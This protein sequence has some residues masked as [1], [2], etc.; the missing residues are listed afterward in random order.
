MTFHDLFDAV[1]VFA[2]TRFAYGIPALMA[3]ILLGVAL[4]VG[5][6]QISPRTS[7]EEE[8]PYGLRLVIIVALGFHTFAEGLLARGSLLG[9][10]YH[11]S[12]VPPLAM[13]AFEIHKALEGFSLAG[14][15]RVAGAGRR[16][17]FFISFAVAT[18][19][20]VGFQF[21]GTLS[22]ADASTMI[23]E[24][25]TTTSISAGLLLGAALIG[26]VPA[27][28]GSGFSRLAG[29]TVTA[30]FIITVALMETSH[31]FSL[32]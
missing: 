32:I 8:Q 4:A 28:Y 20:F 29:F 21:T 25:V 13:L 24:I 11:V 18:L 31:L 12:P 2:S 5:L 23:A 22:V 26:L 14:T 19:L 16:S 15:M 17:A 30:S 3:G 6:Q 7:S 9:L 1:D 10:I 27:A